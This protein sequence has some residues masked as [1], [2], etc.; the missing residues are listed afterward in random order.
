MS[1]ILRGPFAVTA[2]TVLL[3]L[4]A[5]TAW[6]GRMAGME[7][8]GSAGGALA[9]ALVRALGS[10]GLVA[11]LAAALA[12][13]AWF[14]LVRR[15]T[16]NSVVAAS[17][18]VLLALH[19]GLAA[20]RPD[21]AGAAL[22]AFFVLACLGLRDRAREHPGPRGR[23][24]EGCA[25]GS[26]L[27]A[28]FAGAG[29][30]AAPL[31]LPVGALIF[32]SGDG[33]RGLRGELVMAACYAVLA[34]AFLPELW[35]AAGDPAAGWWA[36][37]RLLMGIL[38]DATGAAGTLGMLVLAAGLGG[39]PLALRGRR[40]GPRWLL[41]HL[42]LGLWGF[43]A[44]TLTELLAGP[45][46][47]RTLAL[48]GP[49]L[50]L[51]AAVW[52]LLVALWPDPGEAR[53]D[54]PGPPPAVSWESPALVQEAVGKAVEELALKARQISLDPT[55]DRIAA[56]RFTAAWERFRRAWE[57]EQAGRAPEPGS[58]GWPRAEMEAD[59]FAAHL[60]PHLGPRSRVLEMGAAAG[61]FT[62]RIAPA[63]CVTLVM[64][65]RKEEL[66]RARLGLVERSGAAFVQADPLDLELLEGACVHLVFSYEAL[67]HR[68]QLEIFLALKGIRRVLAP[69]GRAVL[70]FSDLGDPAGFQVFLAASARAGEGK[71]MPVFQTREGIRHL[72]RAAG[73]R[74]ASAHP[75]ANN[76]DLLVEL[77]P[78][79]AP[80]GGGE[81]P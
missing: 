24:L 29:A 54:P 51:P 67:L 15:W 59:L 71:R 14:L 56:R 61:R 52:R 34:L 6:G 55:P 30:L 45:G 35:A 33:G 22:A 76:R 65:A 58:G 40:R 69:G 16:G 68:D 49:A 11:V 9:Q 37:D 7:G 47:G 43:T 2:V 26:Y 13:G 79:E 10:A 48:A 53:P 70:L 27:A 72:A 36:A 41:V 62:R 46:W 28:L 50:L 4:A 77:V 32:R 75:A 23:V 31:L 18:G 17:A 39:L 74:E 42:G 80:A 78:E 19:P 73:L 1:G 81:G 25:L 12:G 5:L 57:A 20:D 38:P 64:D 3:A 66:K 21:S 8:A 44:A 63:A 60:E